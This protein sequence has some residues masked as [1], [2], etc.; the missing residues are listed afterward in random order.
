MS[1]TVRASSCVIPENGVPLTSN[2]VSPGRRP[3]RSATEF[4]SI[5]EI[6]TPIPKCVHF[7]T[8]KLSFQVLLTRFPSPF[9]TY[10]EAMRSIKLLVSWHAN[11]TRY[12]W[13]IASTAMTNLMRWWCNWW[14][15]S[16]ICE[17]MMIATWC[18]WWRGDWIHSF[19]WDGSFLLTIFEVE[20]SRF[21]AGWFTSR[22][23][24]V[25]WWVRTFHYRVRCSR[26][27]KITTRTCSRGRA[28]WT[29]STKWSRAV[30]NSSRSIICSYIFC[31]ITISN[32]SHATRSNWFVV[33]RINITSR[34]QRGMPTFCR[35]SW[36]WGFFIVFMREIIFLNV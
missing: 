24:I 36:W 6:Y 21:T 20:P 15:V 26:W 27:R 1:F 18:R 28:N 3:D 10:T 12:H 19:W 29:N 32:M 5:R 17:K 34:A 30:S 4:S 13:A 2:M 14:R 23:E 22:I 8:R 16:P 11:S 25:M 7:R 35:C 33:N 31:L 9:D